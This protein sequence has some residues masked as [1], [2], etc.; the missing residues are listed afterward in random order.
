MKKYLIPVLATLS[1]FTVL[2]ASAASLVTCEGGKES[3]CTWGEIFK[4]LRKIIALGLSLAVL[5][6][7]IRVALLGAM[8]G[9]K[10]DQPQVRTDFRNNAFI[11]LIATIALAALL[12]L[13][14]YVL[15]TLNVDQ[16][17]IN[18]IDCLQKS[19]AAGCPTS[20]RSNE[21][22]ISAYDIFLS[23]FPHAHAQNLFPQTVDIGGGIYDYFFLLFQLVIRV[24]FVALIILWIY[25][26]FC[27]ISARG[28]PTELTSARNRLWYS[29]FLTVI[30]ALVQAL[31]LAVKSAITS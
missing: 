19:G 26:G 31:L 14:S 11:I 4:T 13:S 7:F 1:A 17:I 21:S 3:L 22:T 16:K 23:L 10:S 15:K 9:L 12:P 6:G 27:L 8:Y 2:S 30:L 28:N 20:I 25:A 5:Y 29:V 24:L 18:P